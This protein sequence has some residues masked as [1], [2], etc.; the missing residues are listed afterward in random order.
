M[1]KK[2][3]VHLKEDPFQIFIEKTIEKLRKYSRIILTSFIAIIIVI[4]IFLLLKYLN[5][6]SIS[7]ENNLYSE[8]IKI[9][10]SKTLSL[11]EKINQLEQL[12][13]RKG[14]SSSIQL[15]LASLY[16][17]KGDLI[18]S[19]EVLG[20]FQES[21]IQLI[22]EKKTL[23]EAEILN[24]SD[25]GTEALDQLHKMYTDPD[26]QITKDY[27]LLKMARIQIKTGQI[28]TASIN[29]KKITEEFPRSTYRQDAQELLTQIGSKE[30]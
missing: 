25:K 14:I 26:C 24:A 2:E 12:K 3:K 18:K 30:N 6:G 5:I 29:L 16:F 19:K 28:E 4:M 20:N 22:N 23:L 7:A 15:F 1:K 13:P 11:D 17:E 21:D 8:A 27:L 10:E 9:Q